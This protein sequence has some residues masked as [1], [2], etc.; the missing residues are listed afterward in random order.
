MAIIAQLQPL[1]SQPHTAIR[2]GAFRMAS[3]RG[4]Y[5]GSVDGVVGVD[6]ARNASLV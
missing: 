5:E 4:H 2:R 3:R 6:V 1:T